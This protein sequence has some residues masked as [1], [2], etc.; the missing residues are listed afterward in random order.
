MQGAEMCSLADLFP[1]AVGDAGQQQIQLKQVQCSKQWR[2][3]KSLQQSLSQVLCLRRTAVN[4]KIPES[5]CLELTSWPVNVR[6]CTS[7]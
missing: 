5:A 6:I 3:S 2:L 4:L 1:E 7:E